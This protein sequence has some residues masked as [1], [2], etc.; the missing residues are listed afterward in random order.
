MFGPLGILCGS[1]G[2]G[3][4]TNSTNTTHWACPDCG[5][6]FRDPKELRN[7]ANTSKMMTVTFCTL[8]IIISL[9]MLIWFM[10]ALG[11]WDSSAFFVSLIP[12]IIF[13]AFA[14][15]TNSISKKIAN[16]ADDIENGMEKFHDDPSV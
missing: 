7:E 9:I 10:S 16:Q 1:C 13:G 5:N 3:Q 8:G 12:V 4:K 2:Q 11:R 15:L 14:L 6:K